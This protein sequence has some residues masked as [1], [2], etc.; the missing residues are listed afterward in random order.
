VEVTHI[1][2]EKVLAVYGP[3]GC[4][5]ALFGYLIYRYVPK[6]IDSHVS[7]TDSINAQGERATAAIEALTTLITSRFSGV[8]DEHREHVFST[9]RTNKALTCMADAIQAGANE[10]DSKVSDAVRPHVAA[11]KDAINSKHMG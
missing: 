10:L 3:L 2:W 5:S 6:M 7:F 4:F 1:D 9:Y 11:I 8:G